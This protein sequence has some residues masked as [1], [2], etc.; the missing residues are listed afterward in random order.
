MTNALA[1]RGF[2]AGAAALLISLPAAAG[3]D[4]TDMYVFGDSLS[5]T[6][7]ISAFFA[8]QIPQPPYADGRFSNGPVWAEGLSDQLGLGPVDPSFTGG[9]NYAWGGATTGPETGGG[10]L[11]PYSLLDQTS[12]Y[13]NDAGGIADPNALYVLWGAGNDVRDENSAESATNMGMMIED[14]AGAGAVNF[15]VL[16][17][18]NIGLTP[19]SLGNGTSA[20]KEALSIEFNDEL[21]AITGNLAADLGLDITLLD[22]FALFNAIVDNPGDFGFSNVS[23]PCYEGQ[24]GLGGPGDVCADPAAYVFWDGIHPTAAAHAMIGSEAYVALT[25][26]PVPAALPLLLGALGF[27]GVARRRQIA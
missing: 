27:L 2:A 21:G 24:T 17:L 5:D 3:T 16:N 20:T 10:G 8:G 19:E 9:D 15:L 12:F 1:I 25:A 11:P 13:L 18:P 23:E 4:Y 6:G 26:V 22:V 7:N 14:L